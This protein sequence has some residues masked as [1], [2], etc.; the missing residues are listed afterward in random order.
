[1]GR[2]KT[3][4][5]VIKGFLTS[6]EY[7]NKGDNYFVDHMYE[8]LL[9]RAFD[10]A[11]EASWF[12]KLGDDASGNPISPPSLQAPIDAVASFMHSQESETRLI[13]G[14]YQVLLTRE[15]DSQGL[16]DWLAKL[17]DHRGAVPLLRRVL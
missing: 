15:A 9:G 11:G 3:E 17:L 4:E 7:L 13:Q 8:S 2:S 16:I 1:L 10:P 6:Q 12:T 5:D 14:Y